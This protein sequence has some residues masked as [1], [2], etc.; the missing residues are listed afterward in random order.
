[1]SAYLALVPLGEDGDLVPHPELV[2][3]QKPGT[4]LFMAAALCLGPFPES[5]YLTGEAR[6]SLTA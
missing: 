2:K 1:V 5:S 6:V 3:A 4:A